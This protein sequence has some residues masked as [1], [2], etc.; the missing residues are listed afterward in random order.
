MDEIQ[1]SEVKANR[2]STLVDGNFDKESAI[3]KVEMFAN[4]SDEQFGVVATELISAVQ[5]KAKNVDGSNDSDTSDAT[6]TKD[7]DTDDAEK[8]SADAGAT[9]DVLD[10][11]KAS[12]NT[13]DET[14]DDT[15]NVD[16]NVDDQAEVSDEVTELA[17]ALGKMLGHE[18]DT[19]GDN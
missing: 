15:G 7:V 14:G 6:D 11:A 17:S 4:L 8:D 5:A 12:D 9:E 1:A 13:G 2:V 10:G 16:L 18:L 19:E 3:A